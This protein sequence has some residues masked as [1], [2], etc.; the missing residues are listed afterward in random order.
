M[1]LQFGSCV[2]HERLLYCSQIKK[3]ARLQRVSCPDKV[4]GSEFCLFVCDWGL[5]P[6]RHFWV[7]GAA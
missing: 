1:D 2:K 7:L 5:F 6:Q 3:I 4:H